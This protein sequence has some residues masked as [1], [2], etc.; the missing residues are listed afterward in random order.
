M[1]AVLPLTLLGA[2]VV[3]VALMPWRRPHPNHLFFVDLLKYNLED[4]PGLTGDSA[5]ARNSRDNTP[6]A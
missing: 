4:R 1:F 5:E 6:V 3:V 2:A